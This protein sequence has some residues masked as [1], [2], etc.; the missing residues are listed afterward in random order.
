MPTN[1]P[2][3]TVLNDSTN[4][5]HS[6]DRE[7]KSLS[8]STNGSHSP[9]GEGSGFNDG[10]NGCHLTAPMAVTHMMVKAVGSMMAPMAVTHLMAPMAVTHLM[11]KAV[12]SMMAPTAV[13]HLPP[14]LCRLSQHCRLGSSAP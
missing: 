6:S 9:D 12:G 5:C 13:I 7:G 2:L 4:G 11:V 8:D 10:T 14:G 3:F 1:L